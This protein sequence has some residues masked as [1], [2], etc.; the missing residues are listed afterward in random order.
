MFLGQTLEEV[1][2]EGQS[3]PA[4]DVDE[5]IPECGSGHGSAE[6]VLVLPF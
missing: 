6:V 1:V 4:L 5:C 3:Q 2:V